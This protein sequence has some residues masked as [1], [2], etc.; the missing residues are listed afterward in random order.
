MNNRERADLDRHITGNYG[1]DQLQVVN[2]DL[3]VDR[4]LTSD[5]RDLFLGMFCALNP[6]WRGAHVADA[7]EALNNADAHCSIVEPMYEAHGEEVPEEGLLASA[8][9][10][11]IY[12]HT[13]GGVTWERVLDI[14]TRARTASPP[15]STE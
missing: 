11:A 9:C 14:V 7:L 10:A 8:T 2:W 15:R 13:P 4:A 1:E 3:A 5:E 12:I 6:H